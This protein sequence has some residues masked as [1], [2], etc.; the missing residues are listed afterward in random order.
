MNLLQLMPRDLDREIIQDQPYIILYDY[1]SNTDAA[2]CANNPLLKECIA[3]K[4]DSG[5]QNGARKERRC[6]YILVCTGEEIVRFIELKCRDFIRNPGERSTWY[7]AFEQLFLTYK[8]YEGIFR[9]TEKHFILATDINRV[10][11]ARYK[12]YPTYRRLTEIG[13]MPVVLLREDE[14]NI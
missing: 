3:F 6:D 4:A 13:F 9:D 12:S 8:E 2:Y 10:P 5:A 7:I 14:D 1:N 11:N